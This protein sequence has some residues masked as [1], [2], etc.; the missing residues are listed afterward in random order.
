MTEPYLDKA[1]FQS[2]D[3]KGNVS[4]KLSSCEAGWA[5]LSNIGFVLV[6]CFLYSLT[7]KF[8]GQIDSTDLSD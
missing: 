3:K 2:E 4:G 6:I 8:T 1:G 5:N 7:C